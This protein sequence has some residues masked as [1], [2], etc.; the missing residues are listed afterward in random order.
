[1]MMASQFDGIKCQ[2]IMKSSKNSR[3]PTCH[4]KPK[5]WNIQI[6]LQQIS[7][8]NFQSSYNYNPT[9]YAVQKIGMGD[10]LL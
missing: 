3:C 8:D 10:R 6:T 7:L 4:K 9:C 1:M 2:S 5:I